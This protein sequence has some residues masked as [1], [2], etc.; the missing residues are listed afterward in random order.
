MDEPGF[1]GLLVVVAVAFLAPFLLGLAPRV[2]LPSVVF[3]IVAGIVIGPAVLGWVEVDQT[4]EV[5]SLVGLAFLLF[6]AGLEIDFSQLRGRLLR[7]AAT[8]W[9]VSFGIA[10]LV[11][12]L[13]KA[14]GLVEAPLLVA[15]IL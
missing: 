12:E 8:G 1:S 7:L 15:I 10:V 3:E 4:I 14:G 5:L 9:A 13:L 6:L 11:G 2:R